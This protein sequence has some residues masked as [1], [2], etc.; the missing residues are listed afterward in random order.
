MPMVYHLG[1]FTLH[2]SIVLKP[3]K[4]PQ[5][6]ASKIKNLALDVEHLP[7]FFSTNELLQDSESPGSSSP[8]IIISKFFI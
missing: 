2:K 5:A 3:L 7:D 4:I 8:A 1:H 6:P